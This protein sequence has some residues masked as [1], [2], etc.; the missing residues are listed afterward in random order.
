MS[1]QQSSSVLQNNEGKPP[2]DYSQPVEQSHCLSAG[3]GNENE[4]NSSK[5]PS[6]KSKKAEKL[7]ALEK[8]ISPRID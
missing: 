3:K 4:D 5:T 2:A 1:V 6:R 8:D 7:A